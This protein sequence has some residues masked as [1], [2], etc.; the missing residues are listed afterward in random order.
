MYQHPTGNAEIAFCQCD[1]D[2]DSSGNNLFCNS[3]SC[4][5]ISFGGRA[6]YET[7]N[8]QR[9]SPSGDYCEAWNGNVSA[10]D[11]FEVVACECIANWHGDQVC[12]FWECEGAR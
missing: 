3:W 2:V 4:K 12:S 8:C 5:Q 10:T 1:E 9:P 6:E 11:E 7:Y